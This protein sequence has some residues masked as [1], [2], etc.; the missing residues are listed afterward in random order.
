MATW[1]PKA[2]GSNEEKIV[3]ALNGIAQLIGMIEDHLA[4]IAKNSSQQTHAAGV[5]AA[6]IK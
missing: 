4:L 2:D 5:I 3:F 6:K 1:K